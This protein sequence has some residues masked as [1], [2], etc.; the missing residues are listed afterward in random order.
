MRLSGT[1]DVA[2]LGCLQPVARRDGMTLVSTVIGHHLSSVS[3]G[4]LG[5]GA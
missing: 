3:Y 4:R 1:S 5:G 2:L